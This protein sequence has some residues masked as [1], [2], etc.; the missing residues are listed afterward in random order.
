[1]I[2]KLLAARLDQMLRQ[3]LDDGSGRP[4][5]FSQPVGEPALVP[6]DSIS[7]QVFANPVSLV[8]GGITA[9][10]LELAEPKVRSGVWDHTTFRTD[11]LKRM[12]RTGMAAMVTVYGARSQATRMISGVR[13]MHEK[14]RG[15]TPGGIPYEAND[16]ELLRWVHATAA[17][18]FLEAYHHYVRPLDQTERD[19]YYAEG[20]PI[21]RLYGA[22]QAPETERELMELFNA[23]LPQLE[24]SAILSEFLGIMESLPLLPRP[25]RFMNKTIISASV[26][27]L[28]PEIRMKLGLRE[29]LPAAAAT[30]ILR[31]IARQ[32]DRLELESSPAV[33]ARKRMNF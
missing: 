21:S 27:L 18:G 8:I 1:M 26:E 10:L 3:Q 22:E 13:R 29:R 28:P 25:L 32:A 6:A 33:Q 4:L 17:F 30:K 31:F 2:G 9:V 14:V 23:T 24:P 12:R 7:W 16:P 5:D 20:A 15:T 11:P 19:R